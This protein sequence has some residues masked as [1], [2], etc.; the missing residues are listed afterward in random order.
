MHPVIDSDFASAQDGRPQWLRV[1]PGVPPLIALD[2]DGFRTGRELVT[3]AARNRIR[4]PVCLWQPPKSSRWYCLPMGAPEHF[5]GGCGQAWNTFDTRGRC[6]GC[7]YQWRHTTCLR[8]Q[9]TSRHD[10]WYETPP[11]GGK[12]PAA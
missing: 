2:R 8:C 1:R 5:T 12:R 3:S 4:C 6:P 11:R 7:S 9:A 10:D